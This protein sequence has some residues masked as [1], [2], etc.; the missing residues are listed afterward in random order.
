M[1]SCNVVG[2]VVVMTCTWTT[3]V[4]TVVIKVVKQVSLATLCHSY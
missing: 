1:K 3:F 2:D 4:V